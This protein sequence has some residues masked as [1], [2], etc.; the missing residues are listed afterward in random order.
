MIEE[1]FY[2]KKVAVESTFTKDILSEITVSKFEDII[3]NKLTVRLE[4]SLFE[5]TISE[6]TIIHFLDKPTFMDWLKGFLFNKRKFQFV[7]VNVS[8]VLKNP[9]ATNENT[10][11]FY[12][13]E[14]TQLEGKP[15][16]LKTK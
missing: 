11:L 5:R 12:S 14:K 15:S 2:K 9:P 1:N 6:K 3:F 13:A 10:I 16:N 8:E 7:K 4:S